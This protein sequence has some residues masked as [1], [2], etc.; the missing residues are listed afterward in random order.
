MSRKCPIKSWL[1]QIMFNDLSKI[2]DAR[3]RVAWR[4]YSIYAFR[5]W[6]IFF[7]YIPGVFFFGWCLS[8]LFND[9]IAYTSVAVAWMVAWI[10]FG[11]P[12]TR[13]RC[14][15]CGEPFFKRKGYQNIFTQKCL[16]CGL[17]LFSQ[18]SHQDNPTEEL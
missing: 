1:L 6:I 7:S 3:Y 11:F 8:F 4:T 18:N 12:F 15:R 14:P 17:A 16:N 10:V 2:E 5:Y 9:E 13:F